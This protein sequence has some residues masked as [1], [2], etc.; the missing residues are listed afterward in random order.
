[1][2]L[3]KLDGLSIYELDRIT[4]LN[5]GGE[6]NDARL[7]E[8][9]IMVRNV[10]TEHDWTDEDE[11]DAL[12]HAVAENLTTTS[13]TRELIDDFR[14]V[15]AAWGQDLDEFEQ[16]A[17]AYDEWSTRIN[18]LGHNTGEDAAGRALYL[19]YTDAA[20]NLLSWVTA[21]QPE[22]NEED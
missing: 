14:T 19:A 12:F 16:Y 5:A 17:N 22:G 2:D 4:E 13:T 11:H 3:S 7:A 1:M 21:N 8:V 15:G 6:G 9:V 10:F 18:D 20:R